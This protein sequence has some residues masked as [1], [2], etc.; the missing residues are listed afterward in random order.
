M[1]SGTLLRLALTPVVLVGVVLLA[2]L[3]PELTGVDSA[4]SVLAVRY[5]DADPDPAVLAAIR[6]D[7]GLDRPLPE[8]VL[9]RLGR[10]CTGQLGTSWLSGEPV[11]ERIGRAFQVSIG[12]V[13]AALVLSFVLGCAAGL[14]AA[15]RP[16]SLVDRAVAGS[17]R[18]AAALPEFALAPL[19]VAVFAVGLD[20]LPSSGWHGP[21]NAVLPVAALVPVLAAP[22]AATMRAR[23]AAMAREN[24]A[25]AAEARGIG[26]FRL[27]TRH[28]AKP[29]LPAVLSVLTYN[30]AGMIAGTATV[31]VVF[32]LPGLGRTLVDA[33]I[34]QDLPVVQVGLIVAVAMALLVGAL[35]D[36]LQ[37]VVDPRTRRAAA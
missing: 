8:R 18:L 37:L 31:E 30:A 3:L 13:V 7:L 24:F 11:G 20:L 27:W 15:R 2:M 19:L 22:I 21:H 26:R 9:D 6:A 4:R 16:G 5:A 29:A 28:I 36:A 12:I 10:L 35:G 23:A 25:V 14:L 17:T 33:V 1:T 34:A 32:D